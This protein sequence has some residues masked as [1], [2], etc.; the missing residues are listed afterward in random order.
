MKNSKSFNLSQKPL[1]NNSK[2]I[3]KKN[4]LKDSNMDIKGNTQSD[5]FAMNKLNDL[6]KDRSVLKSRNDINMKSLKSMRIDKLK[7]FNP[8]EEEIH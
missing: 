8:L 3:T 6:S 5:L 1:F 2:N 7:I 4:I